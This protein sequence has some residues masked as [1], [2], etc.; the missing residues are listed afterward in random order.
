MAK[1]QTLICGSYTAMAPLTAVAICQSD[2]IYV[3]NVAG[4]RSGP[5]KY[6]ALVTLLLSFF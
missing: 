1:E 4:M 3:E 6:M 2:G 5:G